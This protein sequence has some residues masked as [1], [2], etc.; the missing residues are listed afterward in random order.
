[1]TR[2]NVDKLVRAFARFLA[3]SWEA[4]SAVRPDDPDDSFLGDWLQAN[5]EMLVESF[6]WIDG[7]ALVIYSNGADIGNS[8]RVSRPEL[9]PTH[10][11][12]CRIVSADVIELLS[13]QR[14]ESRGTT[15]R[16]AKL[17]AMRDGW[18]Y[19]E[20]PFDC[21]LAVHDE[22]ENLVFRIRDVEFSLRELSEDD[23]G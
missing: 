12:V 15:F 14:F 3:D 7:K 6:L 2:V 10:R 20:P 13:G 16:I 1:M 22:E 17:V 5:W 23:P 19:E 9:L 11:V 4:V 18:Y 21:V 8:S